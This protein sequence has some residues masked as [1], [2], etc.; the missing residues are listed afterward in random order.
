MFWVEIITLTCLFSAN[1]QCF[2]SLFL[3]TSQNWQPGEWKKFQINSINIFSG[4]VINWKTRKSLH[5]FETICILLLG[6]NWDHGNCKPQL[7]SLLSWES[8]TG[9]LN[10][11]VYNICCCWPYSCS[12]IIVFHTMV[13][14]LSYFCN[15][16][17]KE[18][19]FFNISFSLPPSQ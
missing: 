11:H 18:L 6:W 2:L 14:L 7:S 12:Y 15:R 8:I 1:S 13:I 5:Q 16:V 9:K 17:C 3:M 4:V 10:L 19:K